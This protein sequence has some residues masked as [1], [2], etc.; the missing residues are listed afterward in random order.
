MLIVTNKS[1]NVK[2]AHVEEALRI[3]APNVSEKRQMSCESRRCLEL[4]GHYNVTASH[5]LQ[6]SAKRPAGCS[7]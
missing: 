3:K 7:F 2:T 6:Q 4:E 1:I 5:D